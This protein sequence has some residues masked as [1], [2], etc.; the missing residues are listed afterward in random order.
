MSEHIVATFATEND[1]NAAARELEAA[2]IPASSIRRYRPPS[3]T[4]DSSVRRDGRT[5]DRVRRRLLGVAAR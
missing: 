2:G 5:G 1:A 4:T 3:T